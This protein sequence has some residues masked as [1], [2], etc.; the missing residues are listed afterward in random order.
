MP[1]HASTNVSSSLKSVVQSCNRILFDVIE[2]SGLPYESILEAAGLKTEDFPLMLVYHEE[3]PRQADGL[4]D[5]SSL[6]QSLSSN[7]K[8]M[9]PVTFS[10]NAKR[11][12]SGYLLRIEVDYDPN[13]VSATIVQSLCDHYGV[14]LNSAAKVGKGVVV[15][16]QAD[17]DLLRSRQVQQAPDNVPRIHHIIEQLV[18]ENPER[19][20]CWFEADVKVTYHNLWVMIS[21]VSELLLPYYSRR[22][23]R[24][25]IF[26]GPGVQRIAS[27][28]GTL[29]AGLAYVPL[30]TDWPAPRIPAIVRDSTPA[31]VLI[32]SNELPKNR[33]VLNCALTG[34]ANVGPVI[35]LPNRKHDGKSDLRRSKMPSVDALYLAYIMYTSGSTG[36]LKGVK[37]E[38]GALSNSLEEHCRIYR[39]SAGSRLLQFA[40][41]TFDVS[42]VDIFGTLSRGATLCLGSKDFLL[43]RLQEAV[44][45]MGIK[46]LATTPTVAAL[47][48]PE[49]SPTLET[50][51]IGGEPMT[52]TVQG[53]WSKTVRL[54]NVYGP[55]ETTVNVLYCQMRPEYNMGVVGKL[56]RNVKAYIL[57]DQF[58]EVP[59]GSIGQLA[60]GGA[61]L[62][63]ECTDEAS[64]RASFPMHRDFGRIF[65]TG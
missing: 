24:V 42:V 58:Q 4:E 41:W 35:S 32:S 53:M 64:T 3:K 39:L 44:N 18:Q 34:L 60:I 59:V 33:Q 23:G 36:T 10:M 63:R 27:I 25:A 22:D 9:F 6:A 56:L 29:R 47:L 31:V 55:T 12:D 20:T 26:M 13:K 40:P 8:P 46:Y 19:T 37:V 52:R 50:L 38:H 15:G 62:A 2:H 43:S 45:L 1:V 65:L 49:R 54:L 57:N 11:E 17:R 16:A 28:V 61:Q 5:I 14:L 51:A 7:V 30:D 48:S 21:S